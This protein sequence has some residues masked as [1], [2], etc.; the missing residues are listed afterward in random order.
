MIKS[1]QVSRSGWLSGRSQARTALAPLAVGQDAPG[2]LLRAS[3]GFC[4]AP[5]PLFG[6]ASQSG[7]TLFG[8]A[9]FDGECLF[10]FDLQLCQDCEVVFQIGE[11]LEA[12]DHL[13]VA[14]IGSEEIL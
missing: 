2:R 5:G 1:A 12:S 9:Q 10:G 14:R 11:I 13:A 4:V 7:G 6:F 8:F 3:L